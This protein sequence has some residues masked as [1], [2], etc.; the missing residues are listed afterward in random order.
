VPTLISTPS[1]PGVAQTVLR[2]AGEVAVVDPAQ[3]MIARD[4]RTP[5]PPVPPAPAGVAAPAPQTAVAVP[6]APASRV[7]AP[8]RPAVARP[9]LGDVMARLRAA[10]GAGG[11]LKPGRA[12]VSPRTRR[13]TIAAAAVAIVLV[14]AA[15]AYLLTPGV[16]PSGSVTID[17]APWATITRIVAS[18]GTEQPLPVPADTPL[19]LTLPAGV[20]TLTLTGP[21]P[22][23]ET[24]EVSVTVVKDQ[25]VTLA[26]Q[27]FR[28]MTPAEY[29]ERYLALPPDPADPAAAAAAGTPT[30]EAPVAL[31]GVAA[32][33]PASQG[34]VQ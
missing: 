25:V 30:P 22:A 2:R 11:A 20:Y 24:R 29:F 5:A 12:S 16:A 32:A 21:P 27:K 17:A 1:D 3:T 13:L 10:V 15:A 8:A 9:S 14:A 7:A 33:E 23:A 26:A 19:S 34:G 6:P 31:P 4:R 18:D 28:A